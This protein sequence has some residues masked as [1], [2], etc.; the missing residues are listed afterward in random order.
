VQSLSAFALPLVLLFVALGGLAR[1]LRPERPVKPSAGTPVRARRLRRI[2]LN[3]ALRLGLGMIGMWATGLSVGWGGSVPRWSAGTG[4]SL[5]PLL[6]R[7]CASFVRRG[8]SVGLVAVAIAGD[9]ASLMGFGR[10]SLPGGKPPDADTLF[11][12]GSITKVFTGIL[13]AREVE[14]GTVGLDQPISELTDA[15]LAGWAQSLTPRQLTTHTSGLPR[16]PGNINPLRGFG[17]VFFGTDP[18]A[19]YSEADFRHALRSAAPESEPGAKASYSNFGTSLLGYLLAARAGSDY[20]TLVREAVCRPLGMDDT[21]V[22]LE[23][24]QRPRFHAGYRVYQKL[25]PAALGLRSHP[26]T[27]ADHFAGAGGLRSSGRDMLKFLEA[28]MRPDGSPLD[29]TLRSSHRELFR[30]ERLGYGMNWLRR[31]RDGR[32][33]IWHN[34]GTGG[35]ASCLGFT[36]DGNAGVAIL[37]NTARSV[38][39]LANELLHD[40][41]EHAASGG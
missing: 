8:E 34:G 40:L 33:L 7:H 35:Y 10:V 25:G 27:L 9:E 21:T 38:D 39:D 20:E 13:L 28:N 37:S 2:R 19:G 32:T 6:E 17:M 11:E 16:L 30:D 31:T 26:W 23:P 14:R 29:T 22:R 15:E 18:Y 41:E 5:E 36:E 3:G 24:A 12:I 4:P 1:L